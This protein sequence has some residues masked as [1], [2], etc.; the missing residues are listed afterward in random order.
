MNQ[1]MYAHLDPQPNVPDGSDWQ[2]SNH[3]AAGPDGKLYVLFECN[4]MAQQYLLDRN[5]SYPLGSSD[6]KVL[7]ESLSILEAMED[8]VTCKISDFPDGYTPADVD[9]DKRFALS[10]SMVNSLL[11]LHDPICRKDSGGPF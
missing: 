1:F 7:A 2:H 11:K 8:W 6:S 4:V 5:S 9:L 3:I 10:P